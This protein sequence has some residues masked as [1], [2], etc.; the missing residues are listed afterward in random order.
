[1]DALSHLDSLIDSSLS[2]THAQRGVGLAQPP[3]PAAELQ[4]VTVEKVGTLLFSYSNI[5][6]VMLA[7]YNSS[8]CA[9]A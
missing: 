2:A 7:N 6:T 9:S 4:H 8:A 5:I 1:M 3:N